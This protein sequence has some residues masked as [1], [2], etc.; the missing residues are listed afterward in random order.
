MKK[1]I[2]SLVFLVCGYVV[3]A[4]APVIKWAKDFGGTG[5]DEVKSIE[6]SDNGYLYMLGTSGSNDGD[7]S[8]NHGGGDFYLIKADTSGQIIWS[9]T[10]GG[11]D[12][13]TVSSY[14]HSKSIA[15]TSDG[16]CVLVGG[17]SSSDGDVSGTPDYTDLWVVK[18]D[19]AGSVEWNK[20]YGSSS[21]FDVAMSVV[22]DNDGNIVVLGYNGTNDGDAAAGYGSYDFWLL[23]FDASG[24]LLWQKFYGGSSQ[25]QGKAIA[26]APDGN[27]ILAGDVAS[28]DHDLTTNYGGYDF[29]VLKVSSADGSII[30][31]KMY[32]G[33][34]NDRVNTISVDASGNIY[35]GGQSASTDGDVAN[36]Y[37]DFDF[38][39]FKLDNTGAWVWG[40]DFGTSESDICWGSCL[41][42]DNNLVVT[43][44]KGDTSGNRLWLMELDANTGNAVWQQDYD[45]AAAGYGVVCVGN[46]EY[47]AIADGNT[48]GSTDYR[49]IKF[50][51]GTFTNIPTSKAM[52]SIIVKNPVEDILVVK[53]VDVKTV[54]KIT[55][56]NSVGN[57]V[58]ETMDIN[59]TMRIDLKDQ[60]TG[61]Y[62]LKLDNNSTS[63]MYKVIK[64]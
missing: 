35:V 22:E 5:Y 23:K 50:G 26:L 57:K 48:I 10:Y 24:T 15:L 56:Y 12:Y 38:F 37:G 51:E 13:E 6:K 29:W 9:K 4:Q 62:F 43:G 61:L 20:L 1:I 42:S 64:L 32:G 40:K 52:N 58:Y 44:S 45:T 41:T 11:S 49:L 47:Y 3:N 63:D 16:G 33:S 31:S 2:L 55:V 53:G 17:S 7:V 30:W 21:M 14:L 46:N 54:S 34:D 59:S 60:P 19:S 27:Y 28:S 8:G 36:N 25:D 39:V 18:I